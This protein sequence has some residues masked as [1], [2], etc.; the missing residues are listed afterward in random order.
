MSKKIY[1]DD[2]DEEYGYMLDFWREKLKDE[3][4]E[5]IILFPGIREINSDYF[6][7]QEIG[8]CMEKNDTTCGKAWC[9]DYVPRNGKS[10]ICNPLSYF[11][12]KIKRVINLLNQKNDTPIT[13]FKC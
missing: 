9:D 7:C 10:G 3:D 2:T 6:T 8:D 13:R 11:I 5:E 1:F 12:C 4:L